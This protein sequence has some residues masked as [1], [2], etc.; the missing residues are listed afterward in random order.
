VN[1]EAFWFVLSFLATYVACS[2]IAAA[3]LR[4]EDKDIAP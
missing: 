3:V 4:D 2:W 1:L